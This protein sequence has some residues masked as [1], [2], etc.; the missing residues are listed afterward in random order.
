MAKI[1]ERVISYTVEVVRSSD[2]SVVRS[3]LLT[4]D[5]GFSAEVRF[6]LV[7]PAIWVVISGSLAMV[8]LPLRDF[9]DM[10]HLLQTE[11]PVFF[12]AALEDSPLFQLARL[13]TGP[14]RVGQGL[15]DPGVGV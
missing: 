9:V 12:N 5:G 1:D 10:Y 7:Q 6:P 2:S 15:T 4:L 14:E 11:R 13:T 3:L 8:S